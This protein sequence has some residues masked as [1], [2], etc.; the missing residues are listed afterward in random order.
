MTGIFIA[1]VATTGPR[2][3]GRLFTQWSVR[4][5]VDYLASNLDRV[6]RLGRERLRRPLHERGIT[7]QRTGPGRSP[8]TRTPTPRATGSS[9]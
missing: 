6:V 7:F 9:R 1:A 5:L 2:A 3:L 8:P 4:K